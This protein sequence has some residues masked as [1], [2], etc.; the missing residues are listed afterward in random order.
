MAVGANEVWTVVGG[1]FGG[2]ALVGH[3]GNQGLRVRVYDIAEAMIAPLRNIGGLNLS[4]RTTSFVPLEMVTTE[5]GEAI[6]GARVILVCTYGTEHQVVARQLAP[7]LSSGQIV[8]L[9]QGNFA[10]ANVFRR[11]LDAAVCHEKVDVAEMDS[12][13]YGVKV[14]GSD[15]VTLAGVKAKWH[16]VA[17]PASRTD[18]VLEQIGWAFPGMTAASSCLETG[19]ADINGMFHSAAMVTNVGRV[20]DEHSYSFYAANMV[21]SVCRLLERMDDERIELG[22]A[23][24]AEPASARLWLRDAYGVDQ[25]TFYEA[26]QVMAHGRYMLAPAPKSMSHRY[27]IQDVSCIL[28]PFLDLAEVAGIA[29]P[30]TKVV[31]DLAGLL[32][33]RDFRSDGR[34]L[35]VLGWTGLDVEGVRA[36]ACR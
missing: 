10:G 9:C 14:N 29:M 17:S 25:P 13:P 30:A 36:A 3:L 5:V 34:N 12:F 18:Y 19:F 28:V 21:P 4:G 31:V 7:H 22:A 35:A 11:A 32:S 8:L 26:M 27:L 23:Y 24:G 1:G 33:G 6:R 15:S 20:E 16:L 2:K